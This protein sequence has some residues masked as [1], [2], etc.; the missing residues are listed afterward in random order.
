MPFPVLWI[1]SPHT[2][3]GTLL[4]L[5]SSFSE[6]LYSASVQHVHSSW[7]ISS[8]AIPEDSQILIFSPE[9]NIQLGTTDPGVQV[10]VLSLASGDHWENHWDIWWTE[11]Q[12]RDS[13]FISFCPP[14]YPKQWIVSQ[15]N[16][17]GK[18][19]RNERSIQRIE[20][21]ISWHKGRELG[22]FPVLLRASSPMLGQ[23]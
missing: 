10:T 1:L 11:F 20:L 19:H 2:H 3:L 9:P 21:P 4:Y 22:G 17:T 14:K 6:F 5:L 16:W 15:K 18:E 7:M 13:R 12:L 23:G 8:T